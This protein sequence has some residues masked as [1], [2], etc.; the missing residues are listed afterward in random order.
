MTLNERFRCRVSGGEPDG[1]WVGGE[2]EGH[3]CGD[4]EG[5]G[6]VVAHEVACLL[7]QHL[8]H[9]PEPLVAFQLYDELTSI[10]KGQRPPRSHR[11]SSD[12]PMRVAC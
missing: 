1:D 2:E 4:A 3:E 6:S 5:G 12:A 7:L 11:A 9:R 8:Q 10:L